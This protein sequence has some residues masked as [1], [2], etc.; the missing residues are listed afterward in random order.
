[1]DAPDKIVL[2]VLW[3]VVFLLSLTC[4]EAAHAFVAWRGGDDTALRA[5]QVTLN[6]IP[7]MMRE[8]LG[9]ILIPLLTF[10]QT[11]AMIGWASAPYDPHWGARHPERAALMA[12]AGPAANAILATIGFVAL[13]IG[14]S[15]GFFGHPGLEGFRVDQMVQAT[16]EGG[17]WQDGLGRFLSVLL[18]LN[19]ALFLFNLI[20]FPPMDGASILSGFVRPVR[21]LQETLLSSPFA[22]LAGLVIAWMV[23]PR[24]F[25]PVL[26]WLVA[27]LYS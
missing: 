21:R 23:F 2:F 8:P 17:G 16:A 5:G 9:T 14:L 10:F 11:G 13:R 4:H 15:V 1:M 20:P 25:G 19:A 6:P 18:A 12:A 7:H 24:I 27:R 26:G 22:S 3:Y